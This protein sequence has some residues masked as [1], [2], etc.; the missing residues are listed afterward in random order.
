VS[1]WV[2]GWVRIGVWR[3]REHVVSGCMR[4]RERACEWVGEKERDRGGGEGG[5]KSGKTQLRNSQQSFEA[6][7]LEASPRFFPNLGFAF[8]FFFF[9]LSSQID[10][11]QKNNKKNRNGTRLFRR[12]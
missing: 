11:L 4:K 8:F 5:D 9:C 7:P 12:N 6:N 1:E 2:G 3:E 10:C